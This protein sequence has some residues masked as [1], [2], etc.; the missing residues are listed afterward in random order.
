MAEYVPQNE[1]Q[2]VTTTEDLTEDDKVGDEESIS[3]RRNAYRVGGIVNMTIAA[4]E[5]AFLHAK[6]APL[7]DESLPVLSKI[8]VGSVISLFALMGA[9]SF[10]NGILDLKTGEHHYLGTRGMKAFSR[11]KE[12]FYRNTLVF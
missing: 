5:I 7:Y 6:L 3:D 12:A 1:T 2:I 11:A 8:G 10:V 4:A 9:Y